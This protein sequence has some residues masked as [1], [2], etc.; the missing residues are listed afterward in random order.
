[1][2]VDFKETP[3]S[4]T[5]TESPMPANSG[6]D[7]FDFHQDADEYTENFTEILNCDYDFINSN[8]SS[9]PRIIAHLYTTDET[10]AIPMTALLDSGATF[11]ACSADTFET[12]KMKLQLRQ[13][14]RVRSNP[15]QADQ[16]SLKCAGECIANL[17]LKSTVNEVINLLNV[18][19]TII[20]NLSYNLIIGMDILSVLGSQIKSKNSVSLGGKYFSC[21]PPEVARLKCRSINFDEIDLCIS[22]ISIDHRPTLSSDTDCTLVE[23]KAGSDISFESHCYINFHRSEL[24]RP[25]K[26]NLLHNPVKSV[27]N[28]DDIAQQVQISNGKCLWSG[29]IN[30]LA[31]NNPIEDENRKL[32]S[33]NFYVNLLNKSAFSSG[34]KEKLKNI[35]IEYRPVFSRDETDIGLYV[36]EEVE[37]RLR[38]KN[39]EI[40]YLR[41]RP[42]PFAAKEFVREKVKELTERK[43][44]EEVS[45]GSPYNSPAHI[46]MTKKEDG[47]TKFRLTV[48][49]SQLNKF[50]VPD[51]YP[52]PRI[53]DIINDLEGSKFFSSIDLRSGFWNLKLKKECRNLLSFSVGQKQ[54]RPLRLPMGLTTS[55][56][57]FQ[58]IMRQ[59]VSKFLNKFV[60]VY[61]DDCIIYSK[62]AE[63]HLSHIKQ[64]LEAFRKSGILLN[65]DK[66][67]FAVKTLQYLGFKISDQGWQI[68]PKRKDEILNFKKPRDQKEVKRFIGVVGFLTHCS[69]NLQFLLDPLHKI[70]GTKSKFKWTEVEQTAF[71]KIKK[72]I[73]N[74][75]LMAYPK[76]DPSFTMFLST[77]SSDVGWGAVLSQLDEKGIE[78]PLGFCSGAWKGSSV[79]WDIRNKEFHALVNALEY[80]YEFLFAR[81]FVWRCDNQALAFLK[82]SLTGNS[83][84][85]N[86][87]ILRALDFVNM[88]NFSFELKKGDTP[89]MALPDFLSRRVENQPEIKRISQINE[90]NFE[91][92]WSRNA[93]NLADFLDHQK[94]DPDLLDNK[95][96]KKSKRWKFL[97]SKGLTF[98]KCTVTGLSKGLFKGKEKI[99]VPKD[100]EETMI[101]FFHLPV[102]RAPKEIMI[103]LEDYLFPKMWEKCYSHVKK[104]EICV[105]V[106][107]D[108][109]FNPSLTKT[110]T[111]KHPWS[112]LMVDLLGPYSQ[113][114]TGSKYI[115]VIGCQLTGFCLLKSM[116]DKSA[117][118]VI[119][120]FEEIFNTY[121]LPLS[122]SSDNGSEFKNNQIKTYFE[123][124]K[125]AQ[126]FSSPYRPRTQGL[127]E[128]KNQEI[129]KMQKLLKSSEIDWDR[130]LNLIQFLINNSFNRNI[131]MSSFTAFHGWA[132]MV[133]SMGTF[134]KIND[135]SDLRHVDFDLATRIL[136]QRIIINDI[137]SQRERIK[138]SC[139]KSEEK[140]LSENQR[141]LMSIPKPI[142]SSKLWNPWKGIFIVQK[143]LDNDSYLVSPQDDPRRRYIAYRGRLRPLGPPGVKTEN[144]EK[145]RNLEKPGAQDSQDGNLTENRENPGAQDSQD[146]NLKENHENN[147]PYNLRKRQNSDYR[148]Y[149]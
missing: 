68:L 123:K 40:P 51:S 39:A 76:E 118:S 28:N 74:S 4:P 15:S 86:Q 133:P 97:R 45:K 142:G 33:E 134:P 125:I 47:S 93:C 38:D 114:E 26:I 110:S 59:I 30:I 79:R 42:I 122:V 36:G 13:A 12:A 121:G 57:I 18:R 73:E 120:C 61:I 17:S 52:I 37:V 7:S 90:I 20:P 25:L 128:R 54:M 143:R 99:L 91:N 65:A 83:L 48:D 49:Y 98:K 62:S 82:T 92:F 29:K 21:V 130:D 149:F 139:E 136:K 101:L 46:V 129:L 111:G 100:F 144:F 113:T 5:P 148:K 81:Q 124:L 70:S 95:S 8:T 69:E 107:P 27:T 102:H 1:M 112:D 135:H 11:S 132:P 119:K 6:T 78:R 31:L 115:F 3:T 53:R 23:S 58:R 106:K 94:N 138:L 32:I 126:N 84:K 146:K 87:R 147:L 22:Q 103:K 140:P 63:D 72:L 41:N 64:V 56:S 77:D 108:K 80:F 2:G 137:F 16:S 104:C 9:C 34:D 75:V 55:P 43:I 66:C 105:S 19:F 89:E 85:K 88:F 145:S 127:I 35:L 50:L 10:N 60:H 109:S 71:D 116:P 14:V 117:D 131:G 24:E 141:V 44:F 67:Q 96:F